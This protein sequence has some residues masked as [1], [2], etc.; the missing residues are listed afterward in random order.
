MVK[1]APTNVEDRQQIAVWS[2]PE[3]AIAQIYANDNDHKAQD[4]QY[5][6]S[7]NEEDPTNRNPSPRAMIMRIS[8]RLKGL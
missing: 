5:R 2:A 1:P 6:S 8:A 4:G 3:F 7:G